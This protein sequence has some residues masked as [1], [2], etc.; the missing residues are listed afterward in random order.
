MDHK[1]IVFDND[2]AVCFGGSMTH[3]MFDYRNGTEDWWERAIPTS[4]GFFQLFVIDGA[5]AIETYGRSGTLNLDS[6]PGDNIK[7]AIA[8]GVRGG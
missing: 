1:Y 5:I 7:I 2:K 4:A 6:R 8:L 3:S